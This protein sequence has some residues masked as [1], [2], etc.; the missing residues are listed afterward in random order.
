MKTEVR[1]HME[2]MFFGVVMQDMHDML[3]EDLSADCGMPCEDVEDEDALVP[4]DQKRA[5]NA[6]VASQLSDGQNGTR[7]YH[8]ARVA[9]LLVAERGY[10]IKEDGGEYTCTKPDGGVI[11]GKETLSKW[12]RLVEFALPEYQR[13]HKQKELT[14]A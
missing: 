14:D 9:S 12:Q 13:R 8:A 2:K 1:E 3:V 10:A 4:K 5:V 7:L 11:R 6:L